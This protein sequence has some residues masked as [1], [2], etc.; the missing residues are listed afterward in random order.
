MR[1]GVIL[2]L[3]VSILAGCGDDDVNKPYFEFAG[4]GFVANYRTANVYYGFIARPVKAAPEGALIEAEFEM[5]AGQAPEIVTAVAKTGQLQY[6]FRSPNMS[7]LVKGHRYKVILRLKDAK[8]AEIARYEH[9]FLAEAD[10]STVPDQP[11]VTGP[12]YKLN[13]EAAKNL[14]IPAQ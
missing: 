2:I 13:P 5:P 7:S 9:S 1:A 6:Q 11:L 4:G 8:G 3:A 10:R 14:G 12:G